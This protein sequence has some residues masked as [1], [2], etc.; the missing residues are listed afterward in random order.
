MRHGSTQTSGIKALRARGAW[1]PPA[2]RAKPQLTLLLKL[3]PELLGACVDL[4]AVI[5]AFLD[6]QRDWVG[7]EDRSIRIA[8]LA[9]RRVEVGG[10][11]PTGAF[12]ILAACR[13]LLA[14]VIEE[15][16]AAPGF[17][18]QAVWERAIARASRCLERVP[19]R[20]RALP[21]GQ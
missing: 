2:C 7:Y 9:I 12:A 13:Q 18:E 19:G 15:H 20:R 16:A 17:P 10:A 1:T 11:D 8:R 4:H 14:I 21:G 3:V 5:R 6:N